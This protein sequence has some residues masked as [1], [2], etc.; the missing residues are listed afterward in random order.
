M[1]F[2]NNE[3][4][5]ARAPLIGPPPLAPYYKDAFHRHIIN[6]EAAMNPAP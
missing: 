2:T 3:T 6:N 5:P 4:N 1:L